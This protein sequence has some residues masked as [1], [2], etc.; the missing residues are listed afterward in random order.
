MNIYKATGLY[1]ISFT[2]EIEAENI[3]EAM[4]IAESVDISTGYPG[5][6]VFSDEAQLEADG[7]PRDIEV[8]LIEGEEPEED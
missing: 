7:W 1:T 5:N 3:E 4:E 6:I 2:M 8:E